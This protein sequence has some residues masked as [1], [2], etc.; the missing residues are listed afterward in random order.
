MKNN[1]KYNEYLD[2]CNRFNEIPIDQSD[3]NWTTHKG[4]LCQK[5]PKEQVEQT[6]AD[7]YLDYIS[8]RW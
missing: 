2:L 5:L 6:A 7:D 3:R 8:D 4:K 1:P